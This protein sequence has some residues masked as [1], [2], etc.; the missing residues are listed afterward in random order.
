MEMIKIPERVID[1]FGLKNFH[2]IKPGGKPDRT[3]EWRLRVDREEFFLKAKKTEDEAKARELHE[4]HRI[5]KQLRSNGACVDVPCQTRQGDTVVKVD[6]R[7][8]IL[9]PYLGEPRDNWCPVSLQEAGATLA[10]FHDAGNKLRLRRSQGRGSLKNFLPKVENFLRSDTRNKLLERQRTVCAAVRKQVE[11][12]RFNRKY[13]AIPKVLIHGDFCERNI[14]WT[15]NHITA[16]I[17]LELSG[18]ELPSF[19]LCF[20]AS[21]YSKSRNNAELTAVLN[22]LLTGYCSVGHLPDDERELI[23]LTFQLVTLYRFCDD[24]ENEDWVRLLESTVQ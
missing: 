4:L 19:D 5:Q 11:L 1:E 17:D 14:L 9:S 22:P 13:C 16:L 7:L 15:A 21:E 23:K 24:S 20:F 2:I 12:A 18:N 10:R 8:W 3:I 6:H